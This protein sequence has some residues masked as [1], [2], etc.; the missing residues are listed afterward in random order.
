MATTASLSLEFSGGEAIFAKSR[1]E[2]I[3][4]R[5]TNIELLSSFYGIETLLYAGGEVAHREISLRKP[6]SNFV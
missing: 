4:N 6:F 1:G 2:T 5:L 3:L